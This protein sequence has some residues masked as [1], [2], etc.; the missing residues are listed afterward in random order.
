MHQLFSSKDTDLFRQVWHSVRQLVHVYFRLERGEKAI[1]LCIFSFNFLVI[2]CVMA[3]RDSL[4]EGSTLCCCVMTVVLSQCR[5]GSQNKA[6]WFIGKAKIFGC[7]RAGSGE[8]GGMKSN[9]QVF[10]E[11]K[12]P[13]TISCGW[14]GMCLYLHFLCFLMSSHQPSPSDLTRDLAPLLVTLHVTLEADG[15]GTGLGLGFN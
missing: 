8:V 6:G 1:P 10:L 3:V 11:A 5:K 7:G 9:Q 12:C 13:S 4:I 15:G 2:K 14:C